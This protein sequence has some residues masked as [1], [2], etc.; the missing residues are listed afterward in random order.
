M[1]KETAELLQKYST[2]GNLTFAPVS[3][4]I[5]VKYDLSDAEILEL[6]ETE[7][8]KPVQDVN[9]LFTVIIKKVVKLA[10]ENAK[11]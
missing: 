3:E 2:S 1:K 10:L 6:V 4:G 5:E 8:G 11:E 7:Y 9:E